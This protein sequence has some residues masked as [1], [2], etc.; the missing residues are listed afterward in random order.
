MG[1]ALSGTGDGK[2]Q[3]DEAPIQWDTSD[4]MRLGVSFVE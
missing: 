3:L 4:H 2:W 1:V